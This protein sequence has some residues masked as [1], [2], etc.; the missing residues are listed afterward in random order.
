M[1]APEAPRIT[2]SRGAQ[3]AQCVGECDD[4]RIAAEED[5]G[6]DA[7]ERLET[8]VGSAIRLVFRRPGEE[9]RVEAGL[10]EPAFEA[11]QAFARESDMLLFVRIG[12]C[13]PQN[14]QV[15]AMGEVNDLPRAGQFRREVGNRL[16][17]VDKDGDELFV[18]AAGERIFFEAPA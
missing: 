8:T 11:P 4:R 18:E 12:V 15:L 9:F 10:F 17:S 13:D 3:A 6:I 14:L 7:I 5:P 1:P 2:R 16:C